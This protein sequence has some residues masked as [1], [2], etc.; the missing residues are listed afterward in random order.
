RKQAI[1]DILVRCEGEFVPELSVWRTGETLQEKMAK[2]ILPNDS[3]YIAKDKE[4]NEIV[5]F[6]HLKTDYEEEKMETYLPNLKIETIIIVPE[7]RGKGLADLLYKKID[8]IN[9]THFQKPY[10]VSATWDSN[11][12]QHYLFK[13]NNYKEVLV[14]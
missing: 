14:T 1:I 11:E 13:K 10:I 8:D 4:T 7:Y 6:F 2:Y 3:L 5:G 12:K 9:K